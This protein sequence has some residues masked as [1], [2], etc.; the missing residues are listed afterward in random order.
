M[1]PSNIKDEYRHK[2]LRP[3]RQTVG[4]VRRNA[5]HQHRA[6]TQST[7][8]HGQ[9]NAWIYATILRVPAFAWGGEC[10]RSHRP[11][12]VI[13]RAPLPPGRA[14]HHTTPLQNNRP[15]TSFRVLLRAKQSVS[16]VS[17]SSQSR[18]SLTIMSQTLIIPYTHTHTHT[19]TPTCFQKHTPGRPHGCDPKS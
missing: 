2:L 1:L 3:G 10:P 8:T 11:S 6:P 16:A 4:T 14:T 7:K 15:V 18:L 12:K 9:P 13:T 19:H 17:R 5:E